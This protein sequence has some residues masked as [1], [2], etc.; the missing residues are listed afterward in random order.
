MHLISKHFLRSTR[1]MQQNALPFAQRR[2]YSTPQTP[3]TDLELDGER[4]IK[5]KLAERFKPSQLQVQDVSGGCGSFYAIT[6]ASKAFAGIPM[7]KQH[8]LVNETLKEEISG[9]HGLQTIVDSETN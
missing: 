4:L 8:R 1:R 9:I 2:A 3:P 6:I 7:V 5:S